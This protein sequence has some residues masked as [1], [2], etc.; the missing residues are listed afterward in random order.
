MKEEQT[1]IWAKSVKVR[2]KT[3]TLSQ[4]IKDVLAVFDAIKDRIANPHLRALIGLAI[5]CHDFGKVLPAFQIRTLKNREYLPP[6]LYHNIPH[7]LFSV[8]WID[9][10]D[11]RNRISGWTG[12][13]ADDYA[14]FVVSAVAYHHWRERFGE[15][16]RARSGEVGSLCAELES[17][18]YLGTLEETLKAELQP[19]YA[20]FISLIRFNVEMAGGLGR[21]VAFSEYA[22][23]PYQL[24]WLPKR[25][26][27]DRDRL[28][29]WVLI[30]GFLM[31]SDH[32]ASF[33]EE[34][35]EQPAP[36]A[37]YPSV[38]RDVLSER[39]RAKIGKA[40][41]KDIWQFQQADDLRDRS[42]ILVAPTGY[43]KTEFAFLWSNSEKFFY[44]LPLR[45]AVN[46]TFRRAQK[47]FETDDEHE[48]V[49][50]LHS[51]ADV[52]LLGDGGESENLKVYDL[53]R[54]LAY[55]AIISTGDQFFPYA[56]R[57]PGYEKI[58]A[59][60]SY[61][62]LVIDEVQ[63]YDP[64]AAAIVVKFL[65][66]VVRMGGKFLLMTATLPQFVR[67]EIL[68][69]LKGLAEGPAFEER[70]LYEIE[71]ERFR[72]IKKH[73]L[74]VELIGKDLNQEKPDFT[75]LDEQVEKILETAASGKR[76]LVIANT[77]RQAQHIFGRLVEK[78][79]EGALWAELKD[80]IDLLHSRFTLAD[81]NRLETK[82]CGDKEAGIEGT[83]QNPKPKSEGI[84]KIL[85]A[86]Q[87][88]EASLDIDADVL[89]TEIAPLDALVQRIGRVLRRFGPAADPTDFVANIA[90]PNVHIWVFEN[91]LHSGRHYVYENDLVLLTLKIL[92]DK[93]IEATEQKDY[94]DW[95][96]HLSSTKS[97]KRIR[98]VLKEVF[99]E[100][101]RPAERVPNRRGA[102]AKRAAEQ[103]EPVL[104]AAYQAVLSE[105]DKY[106][107]VKKLYR[108]PADH[109]YLRDFRQTKDILDAG[110]M[111]DRLSDAHEMFRKIF[112]AS[113][114][115]SCKKKDFLEAVSIFLHAHAEDKRLYTFFKKEVFAQFVVPIPLNAKRLAN[116]RS[117][118]VENWIREN[119]RFDSYQAR[120][121]RWCQDIYFATYDYKDE[122]G[123]TLDESG[124]NTDPALW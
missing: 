15:L 100:E 79:K 84:G 116:F 110:Y 71:K 51:D 37:E 83:F 59:T 92:K 20:D 32:F 72:L 64:R 40:N 52:F 39:I 58:H 114:V 54:Q 41:D 87:V 27:M 99:P 69:A 90:D 105:F 88:I 107:L 2:G 78:I 93:S 77:V 118:R 22:R 81:R 112:S 113:V 108:L 44:T 34:G 106:D 61:S 102:K 31:R 103:G 96:S 122:T 47:L 82:I 68:E 94:K 48:R 13:S 1:T 86:T 85:V 73:F 23:P 5:V 7:S 10:E 120:L 119:P 3:V 14:A 80:R 29:E 46:Q 74:R 4:H 6:Y 117:Q 111:S 25:I 91:G 24:Y 70:N 109:K 95:I 60:F 121:L 21:G 98:D 42:V 33:C 12:K 53:A 18:G 45:T 115:P 62:R 66:D 67:E 49:G 50:L 28:K 123:L 76:V 8:L 97:E 124:D 57:P 35:E 38:S 63:A 19:L 55:P 11:L 89:F 30:S 43:G 101:P 9:Q 75:L 56:L 36:C 26:T 65:E 104:K 17:Q 16:L